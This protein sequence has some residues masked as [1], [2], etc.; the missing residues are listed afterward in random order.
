[1]SREYPD[2]LDPWKAA[3]G[4]RI[5]AGLIP[6]ARMERLQPLLAD[7]AGEAHF[8]A[9]FQF[10]DQAMVTIAMNVTADLTLTCQS[11]LESYHESVRRQSLL[12]VIENMADEE[13]MPDNYES[14]L[15]ENHRLALLELVEDELLL[16]VPQVPRN[17]RLGEIQPQSR[18]E[19]ES[20]A[21]TVDAEMRQPFAGLAEQLKKHAQDAKN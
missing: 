5:F 17:P 1:M 16:G 21:V 9:E 11:S 10:D 8:T 19:I 2:W 4:R 7:S 14:V 12:G 13:L 6:L 18:L 15:V 3:E 20:Q